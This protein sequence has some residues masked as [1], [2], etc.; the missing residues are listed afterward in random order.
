M[1]GIGNQELLMI[2]AVFVLLFGAKKLPELARGIGS[3]MREF[4]QSL[5]EDQKS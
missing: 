2:L 4:K 5:S 3:S 1:F